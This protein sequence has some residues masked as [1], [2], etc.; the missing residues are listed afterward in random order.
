M[1]A[2]LFRDALVYFLVAGKTFMGWNFKI[3]IVA[4][5]AVFESGIGGMSQAQFTRCVF[6]GVFLLGKNKKKKN[7]AD[8]T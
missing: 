7:E 4:L 3:L 6:N 2:S 1:I 5:H 8:K